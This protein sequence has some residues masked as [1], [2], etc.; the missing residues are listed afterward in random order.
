MKL[1]K[2]FKDYFSFSRQERKGIRALIILLII[3][4]CL[5]IFFTSFNKK[6]S[7]FNATEFQNEIVEWEKSKQIDSKPLQLVS[8]ERPVANHLSLKNFDPNKITE[9]ELKDMGI[10]SYTIKNW[11]KYL[12]SGG[13]FY[14]PEDLYKIYTLDSLICEKLIPFVIISSEQKSNNQ[15]VSSAEKFKLSINVASKQE[16]EKLKGIGPVLSGRIINY[17]KSLGGYSDILQI[18]EVFGI[19]DSS[20]RE[21]KDFI[22]IDTAQIIK[23]NINK[24]D[25][26]TLSKHPYLNKYYAKSIISYKR[27]YGPIKNI[28]EL[29]VNKVIP[30]SVYKKI[31]PYFSI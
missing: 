19:T 16:L 10:N 21:I 7:V 15:L 2:N 6:Q 4:V 17:R 23:L 26:F 14:K 22:F 20:F 13:K 5:R 29:S 24:S 1:T 8:L 12:K 25:E 31:K 3:S 11:V 30:D 18:K 9:S 28:N 27:A